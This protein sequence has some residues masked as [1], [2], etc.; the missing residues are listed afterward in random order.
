M[1][2]HLVNFPIQKSQNP[3]SSHFRGGRTL[4]PNISGTEPRRDLEVGR[5]RPNSTLLNTPVF[6][7]CLYDLPFPRYSPAASN[8]NPVLTRSHGPVYELSSKKGFSQRGV[9]STSNVLK[10]NPYRFLRVT[11]LHLHLVKFQLS[12][13]QIQLP[14]MSEGG[15]L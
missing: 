9:Q 8:P 10:I 7:A 5:V 11:F 13:P 6:P 14:V 3:A 2:L 12:K 1:H 4:S 15:E